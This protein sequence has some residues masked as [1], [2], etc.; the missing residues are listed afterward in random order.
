MAIIKN[1][2]LTRKKDLTNSCRT[3]KMAQATPT[4]NSNSTTTGAP[5]PNFRKKD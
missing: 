3:T 1:F 4:K 2:A 5:A